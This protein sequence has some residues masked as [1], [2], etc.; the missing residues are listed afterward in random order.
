[1]LSGAT[2]RVVVNLFEAGFRL[3]Q[4]YIGSTPPL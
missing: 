3:D 4:R 1:M 2:R